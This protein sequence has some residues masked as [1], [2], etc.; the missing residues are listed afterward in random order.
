MKDSTQITQTAASLGAAAVILLW[1]GP[2]LWYLFLRLFLHLLRLR[3]FLLE[4][5]LQVAY[6]ELA[7][8][9]NQKPNDNSKD[10]RGQNALCYAVTISGRKAF[11]L[12]YAIGTLS[13]TSRATC[14]AIMS[15]EPPINSCKM[16]VAI[17]R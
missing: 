11:R 6:R 17:A 9:G 1:G 7:N 5:Y 8:Y 16:L 12:R 3:F 4:L 14:S 10:Y 2:E 15:V 13:D